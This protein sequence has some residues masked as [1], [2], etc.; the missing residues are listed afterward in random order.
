MRI[1]INLLSYEQP[2][3][4]VQQSTKISEVKKNFQDEHGIP[5]ENFVFY[6]NGQPLQSDQ[7]LGFYNITDGAILEIQGNLI[8]SLYPR[9][10]Q[11]SR[12]HELLSELASLQAHI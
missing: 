12:M 10:I 1:K 4:E 2:E 11:S 5:M 8:A 7:T 3:Y 9:Y 6:F